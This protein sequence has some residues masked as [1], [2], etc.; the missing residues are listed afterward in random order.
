MLAQQDASFSHYWAMESSFNPAAVGKEQKLN[1]VADYAM[2][3]TGFEHNP[4]TMYASVDMPFFFAGAYHGAGVQFINDDIGL[5]AHKRISL[6]YAY[7]HRLLG[8]VISIGVQGTL[9]SEG[10]EG[11]K[12]DLENASDPVFQSTDVNG[13]GLDLSAGLYYLHGPWYVG[14]SVLHATAPSVELGDRSILDISRTYYLT[15]G[16]NIRLRNPFLTI[17]PS[18]LARYDG[19]TYRVD[20]TTRLKYTHEQRMLYVGAACS[21][22]NSVTLLVGGNFHGVCL[23]YSYEMYTS[24]ISFGNGAHEVFLGYQTDINLGKRGRNRHKSVRLL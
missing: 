19:T 12:L 9:M 15:G 17:H 2:A 24:A 6:Q 8:G 5:F 22:T 11:S 14:A 4:R 13:V 1:V 20:V 3:L 18:L 23:G 10:F 16:Y 21:P 7:K